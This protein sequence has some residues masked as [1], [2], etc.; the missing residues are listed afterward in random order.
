MTDLHPFFVHFPIALLI[1]AVFFDFHGALKSMLSSTKTAFIL[2][3]TASIGAL[4]AAISGNAVESKI[5]EQEKLFRGISEALTSHVSWG[6]A[7]VWII[8]GVLLGRIFTMLEQKSWAPKVWVFSTLSLS[9][10]ILVLLTGLMGGKLS[11]EILQ[12]FIEH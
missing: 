12:Y 8:L 6:N 9:L 1:V 3:V 10:A 7:T 2:Q 4:L 5:V 11:Q